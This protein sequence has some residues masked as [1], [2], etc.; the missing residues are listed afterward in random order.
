MKRLRR[1]CWAVLACLV[2]LA[3][4]TG[5]QAF[6]AG[7]A[8]V[9]ITPELGTPLNGYSDRLGRGAIAVHDPLWARCLYLDDGETK[10]FLVTADLCVINRELR[11]LVLQRAPAV[12]PRENVILTATHTHSGHGGMIESLLFRSV[13]GRFM[14]EV[15][16][17]TA[18]RFAEVMQAAYDARKRATIGYGTANQTN[19]STNRRVSGGV[20]DEQ[21]GVIRVNDSDGNAIAIVGNFTA[22]PT[23][24]PKEDTLSFSADYPGYYCDELERLANPGCVAM[25]LQGAEGNQ[26]CAN[27]ENKTGWDRTESIGRL[28]AIS[29]KGEANRVVCKEAKLRV[30]SAMV[31]LPP[32]LAPSLLPDKSFLQVL[33]IDDLLLAFLPGEPCVE[34][35]LGLRERALAQ[36]YGAQFTVGLANDHLLYFV[37][38]EHYGELEYESGM[39]LYGPDIE[40]W[41]YRQFSALGSLGEPIAPRETAEAAV[42]DLAPGVKRLVLS[43]TPYQIGYARGAAFR[44][45]FHELFETEYV[46]RCDSGELIPST[47]LWSLAPSFFDLTTLALP[48]LAIAAR[49]LLEGI[50]GDAYEELEGMADGAG[51]PFDAVW[52]VQCTPILHARAAAADSPDKALEE[53]YRVPFCTMAAATGLRAGADD[54]LVA[55]NMDWPEDEEPVVIEVRPDTGHAVIQVGF[56]WNM[57]VFTGMNDAGVVA[58][59][60]RV[61]PLGVPSADGAPLEVVLRQVLQTAGTLEEA[62]EQLKAATHLRGYHVLLADAEESDARVLEFGK[63]VTVREPEE[64]LLL[65]CVPDSEDIDESARTR[66]AR[67]AKLLVEER[68]IAVSEL[69]VL[70]GD[71][72]AGQKG[73]A[74]IF[75]ESTQHCVVFEPKAKRLRVAVR[76]EDGTIGDFTAVEFGEVAP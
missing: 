21:V 62:A 74:R 17:A 28:L 9:E 73:M 58:C 11:D 55:R 30:N 42:A 33:E 10:V 47:G 54:V 31:D 12:V 68:I 63:S 59:A 22:H 2:C 14:P 20:I 72:E 43:G 6:E 75:N 36:G 4:C 40:H 32:T 70:L 29:V 7:A 5:A 37:A 13:S 49:P 41:L 46:A 8:K 64:G 39:N 66:Y 61:E 67:A 52:L 65:G 26:R 34:I 27:P 44:E 3:A 19:L 53:M 25:F 45:T 24:V 48:R 76:G 38:R 18:N 1:C 56:R 50:S 60:E 23:N 35:A 16:D 57:G 15:L 69:E 71:R 51:L